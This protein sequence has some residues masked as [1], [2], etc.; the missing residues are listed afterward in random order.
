VNVIYR[1]RVDGSSFGVLVDRFGMPWEI[2]MGWIQKS[3]L[4]PV[5]L[6]I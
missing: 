4:S 3:C 2:G 5:N 1:P 6:S